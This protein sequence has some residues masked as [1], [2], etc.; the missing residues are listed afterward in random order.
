MQYSLNFHKKLW[1]LLWVLACG[2]LS[3]P[4]QADPSI[5]IADFMK[6]PNAYVQPVL[7][8]DGKSLA[9]AQL[10]GDHYALSVVD[11]ASR[12]TKLIASDA[13]WSISTFEWVNNRR[14]VFSTWKGSTGTYSEQLGAGLFAVDKDGSNFRKLFPMLKEVMG[15]QTSYKNYDVVA[16]VPEPDSDDL[17][18]I[19][20]ESD[21]SDSTVLRLNTKSGRARSITFDKP[22]NVLSWTLDHRGVARVAESVKMDPTTKELIQV[23]FYRPD[24][25]DKWLQI[26]EAKYNQGQGI[27]ILGFDFDN[28]KLYVAGR[29]GNRDKS[30]IFTWNFDTQQVGELIAE[31]PLVDMGGDGSALIIDYPERKVVGLSYQA[32]LPKSVFFD[33][34]YA[35]IA[36]Q[37]ED[38]FPDEV[39]T[40][41]PSG[42]RIIVSV[43][44][45]NNPGQTYVFDRNEKELVHVLS[46]K[47]ELAGKKLSPQTVISY[48]ARDGLN[49]PAY[50]TLPEGR[51]PEKLPLVVYV[52]GGPQAR[53]EYG[54]DDLGQM[55]ASRGYAVLQPQFRMSTGF[56]WKHHTAGWKEWGL[57]MQDDLSD[58]VASLVKQG[59]VD[60][61]R[62]CIMGASYGGYATMYGLIKDPDLYQC[63]INFVGATDIGLFFSVAWSDMSTIWLQDLG[64]K[65]HGDP[66]RDVEYMK[67]A[68]ALENSGRIK[69]PVLMAYG[70]EDMRIPL[71]H[72]EKMRDKLIKQ[73]TPLQWV[74][75][76]GEGH[77]WFKNENKIRWGEMVFKFVSDHIGN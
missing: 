38:T 18:I 21:G 9:I 76:N 69:A 33:P 65:M 59:I 62:V 36:K 68:S 20:K 27:D 55:L 72:G 40:L 39:V 57:A 45:V 35:T 8:P 70:S 1:Q 7:S 56:G 64:K 15:K 10:K 32:M 25:G 22:R 28:Q 3:I 51:T 49:I 66:E 11:L 41:K 60:P 6:A 42:S 75:F 53:D 67:N 19:D 47:P 46:F 43:R 77:G 63:G 16:R 14:L 2:G 5:P 13:N 52:H 29:F 50:L 71:I 74:V 30:A 73:G 44:G 34:D 31:D 58:G 17:F 23:I 24:V 12:K 37:L 61:A 26:Y 4:A 48:A 54:F